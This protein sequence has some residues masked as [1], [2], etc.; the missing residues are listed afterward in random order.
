[1]WHWRSS[2]TAVIGTAVLIFG[3]CSVL[4]SLYVLATALADVDGLS[5]L[6]L[7][8]RQRRLLVTTAALGLGTTA[9]AASVGVPLGAILARSTLPAHAA[10]RAGLT[11][12]VLLPPYIVALAWTYLAG[13]SGWMSGLPGAA[14]VLGLVLYPIPMLATEV[15]LRRV[16]AR[17]E[18]AGLLV[19]TRSQVLRRI[20][21]PLVAPPVLAASLVV[22]VLAISDFA[23]PGLLG[24]RV[25]TTEILTAFAALYDFPRAM[26]LALP[27][28]LLCLGIG[29]IASA[30]MHATPVVGRRTTGAAT[31][32]LG[33]PPVVA[34]TVVLVVAAVALALPVAMLVNEARG[35]HSWSSVVD[36]SAAA[37]WNS[38]LL[39]GVGATL[40]VGVAFV[41][42]YAGARSPAR[43]ARIVDTLLVA[44]FGIPSTIVGV[45]LIALWNRPGPLGA[46]YGTE[47]ML[48]LGYVGR[49]L[50]VAAL[51]MAAALRQVPI[52]HEEAA[53]VSGAGWLRSTWRVVLPQVR[54]AMGATWILTFILAFGELGVSLLVAPPGESTLPIRVY[55]LIANAPSSQVAGLA[56]L[57]AAV[58]LVPVALLGTLSSSRWLEP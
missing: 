51:A 55:T 52:S 5:A 31:S 1:M 40:V 48:V 43:T 6:L 54:L 19:A 23:V 7:D 45:G 29:S 35:V 10:V 38:V 32:L 26:V 56:L 58:I 46:I 11:A 21:L 49:Y 34:G 33:V 41:I 25:Y 37:M 28:L 27:L 44:A 2:R 30:V 42:G 20:T 13:H 15:A 50:P 24:V 22:F 4:P 57:Q 16:D 9:V 53:A 14:T 17:L 8:A 36:G 18:E 47:M 12:P 3:L 39:A